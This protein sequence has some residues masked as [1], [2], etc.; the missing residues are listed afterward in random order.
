MP[1]KKVDNLVAIP[2]FRVKYKDIFDIK[3]FYES[4]HEWLLEYNWKDP[5]DGED[6]WETYYAERIDQTGA[7]E[8][9]WQWRCVK[10][11]SQAPMLLYYLD[12][13]VHCIAIP[14]ADVVKDGMKLKVNKGEIELTVSTNIEKLYEKKF[15]KDST[16]GWL[17]KQMKDLFTQR[18]YKKILEERTKELYQETYA[19]HN[20]IKQWF[21]LKRYLPYEEVKSFFPSQAWPSHVKE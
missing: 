7:R 4:L 1:K 9:W 16:W 12:L 11:P 10:Q 2:T 19:L 15:D 5:E 3:G 6:H 13:N 20:F 21:K 17:L 14:S 8:I 18:V